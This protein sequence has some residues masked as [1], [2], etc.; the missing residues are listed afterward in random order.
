[1]RPANIDA[2]EFKSRV[3]DGMSK[4]ALGDEFGVHH[5]T[6]S[7]FSQRSGV[8]VAP[9]KVLLA[10]TIRN[11]VRDMRPTDAVEYLLNFIESAMPCQDKSKLSPIV[12]AGFSSSEAQII[13]CISSREFVTVTQM[14]DEIYL[15]R[16]S[17]ELP[18]IKIIPVHICR[19][20]KT[21]LERGWDVKIKTIWGQ[22]YR[23]VRGN[24]FLFPWER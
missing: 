15:G 19:L 22:G 8:V 4:T 14:Y 9:N 11:A 18:H 17:G 5:A 7:R 2:E 20:R 10:K 23:L 13:L 24:D 1:M 16:S 6:I 12:S 21:F 3:A